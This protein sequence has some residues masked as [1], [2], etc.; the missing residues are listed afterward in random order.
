MQACRAE[1]K[2][3]GQSHLELSERCCFHDLYLQCLDI[4]TK[5]MVGLRGKGKVGVRLELGLGLGLGSACCLQ[6][7][8]TVTNGSVGVEESVFERYS[9]KERLQGP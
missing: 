7:I 8:D 9:C 5:V 4:V 2:Q 1:L 6:C 3:L